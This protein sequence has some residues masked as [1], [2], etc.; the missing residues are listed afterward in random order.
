[1]EP[2]EAPKRHDSLVCWHRC[3]DLLVLLSV[4]ASSALVL[5]LLNFRYIISPS[6]S[7]PC[8]PKDSSNWAHC[9][10]P[11]A[12]D[13]VALLR[14]RSALLSSVILDLFGFSMQGDV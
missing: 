4:F 13:E 1:M 9:R 10:S 7:V 11:K 6:V 5:R 8:F 3:P 12:R 2:H 14:P